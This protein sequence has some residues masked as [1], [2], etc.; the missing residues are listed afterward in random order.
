M[1]L[2]QPCLHTHSC[3]SESSQARN[4]LFSAI[5][6]ELQTPEGLPWL[7]RSRG[8]TG[9]RGSMLTTATTSGSSS[10][11]RCLWR[12][13]LALLIP[14]VSAVHCWCWQAARSL[15][16]R[17]PCM[18]PVDQY[19]SIADVPALMELIQIPAEGPLHIGSLIPCLLTCVEM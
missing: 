17:S 3:C 13:V 14:Q 10:S 11:G 2:P 8:A 16:W 19:S 15:P 18:Q 12:Y 7:S 6:P 5:Q 4:R 9:A 1:L